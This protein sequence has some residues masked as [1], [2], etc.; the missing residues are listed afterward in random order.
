MS[1]NQSLSDFSTQFEPIDPQEA[2]DIL[3]HSPIGIFKTTPEGRY[4]YSNQALADMYGYGSPQELMESITDITAQLYVDPSDRDAFIRLIQ[5]QGQVVN[6]ECRVRRKDGSIVWVSRNAR[7]VRDKYGKI[8]HYQGFVTDIT[9]LK[10]SQKDLQ[11]NKEL[12]ELITDNMRDMVSL[13][14]L[15]GNFEFVGRSHQL[16]G[17]DPEFLLGKNVLDFVHPEDQP[18]IAQEF[19]EFLHCMDGDRKAEYRYKK[20]DGS[21]VW[22]ETIGRFIKGINSNP[23]KILFNTRDITDRKQAEKARQESEQK[24][25]TL[26]EKCPTSVMLL[27]EQGRVEFVNDWH[28]EKFAN[29][30]LGKDYF[31]GKSI[32]NLPGLVNAGVDTEVARIFQGESIELENVYIPELPAGGSGWVS[33]RAVPIYQDDRI[34]G[35]ILIQENITARKQIESALQKSQQKF[36]SLVENIRDIIFSLTPEGHFSYL[37]PQVTELLGY[38]VQELMGNNFHALVHPQDLPFVQMHF[39]ETLKTGQVQQGIEPRLLHRDGHRRWFYINASPEKNADGEIDSIVGVAC[40]ITEYKQAEEELRYQKQLLE[41]IINGTWDILSIKQPDNTIERYNQAGYDLLGLPPE[42]VIGRKCFELIGRDQAC[43]PC[44]TQ[45]AMEAKA[46]V[47]IEKYI[48]ELGLY[49]D[50]RSSPVLDDKGNLVRIVEHL[51][52]ITCI[53]ET[54]QALEQ[55][56]QEAEAANHAKSMFLANMSHEI[57]TPLNGIMGMMQLLESTELDEEQQEY[58]QIASNASR[59]LTNLLSDILDLSKIEAGKLEI[60]AEA[61]NLHDLCESVT[62]LFRLQAQDKGLQLEYSIDPSLPGEVVGDEKRLQQI[63]FNLVGNSL[64]YTKQGSIS[65]EATASS[66]AKGEQDLQLE[67]KV[68]DT[69]K[70]I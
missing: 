7:E 23:V 19:K 49:L 57:R 11:D 65:L 6:Q 47:N 55:A 70:G 64:K 34:A 31:L 27:D 61:F 15:E 25:R 45:Q 28:I 62:S 20:K 56:K 32:H 37:S 10:R 9:E 59:R 33:I 2:Q 35:G 48:P 52:D 26:A 38:E 5:E 24:F 42:K 68:E 13:T 58:V 66:P 41:T 18:R 67:F 21:Y 16:L 53:K 39:E 3:Q 14:D 40:D 22:L 17:Y 63:L 51:R 44:V 29:N 54:E 8:T 12:L 46:S 43:Q 4:L 50:C 36:R 1:S 69:G 30:K 60:M